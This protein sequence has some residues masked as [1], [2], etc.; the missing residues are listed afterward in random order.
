MAVVRLLPEPPKGRALRS[1]ADE[2]RCILADEW[3]CG[4]VVV[5][6][7]MGVHDRDARSVEGSDALA[8]SLGT[9][10]VPVAATVCGRCSVEQ[11]QIALACHI[12]FVAPD[13]VF[14][15]LP[16]GSSLPLDEEAFQAQRLGV[17]ADSLRSLRALGR[18]VTTQDARRMGLARIADDPVA[19]ARD[20]LISLVKGRS[21]ASI[22]AAMASINNATRMPEND[23]CAEESRL[24]LEL[25]HGSH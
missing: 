2:V 25:V 23:A 10:A 5:I 9:A 20:Y 22:R 7:D 19:A 12:R 16:D 8:A 24:F 17:S 1:A 14:A 6:C 13:A 21:P 3:V 4:I 18:T 11:M 15:G